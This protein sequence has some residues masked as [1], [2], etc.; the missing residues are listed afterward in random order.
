LLVLA[1]LRA[2]LCLLTLVFTLPY[3]GVELSI[4]VNH[5]KKNFFDIKYDLLENLIIKE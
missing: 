2:S 4:G 1:C 3:T 5:E